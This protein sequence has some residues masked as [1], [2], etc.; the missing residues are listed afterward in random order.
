[1]SWRDEITAEFTPEQASVTRLTV[2]S[3]P[4]ELLLEQ[5][6]LAKLRSAGFELVPFDDHVA[7][8][9]LY[10]RRFRQ[11]WDRGETTNLVVVLRTPQASVDALP[12]DLLQ[13][14][15]RTQRVL[16]FG[17]ARV[18][19]ELVP[20]VVR[21]LDPRWF[22]VLWNA[23]RAT[24]QGQLN[25]SQTRAFILRVVFKIV[26]EHIETPPQMLRLLLKRHYAGIAFPPVID[27]YLI[28]RLMCSEQWAAWPL[29]IVVPE[30]EAF[31]AFLQERWPQFVS[32]VCSR[33]DGPE[34]VASPAGDYGFNIPGPLDLPFGHDDVKAYIDRLFTEGL[35]QRVPAPP[36]AAA[37]GWW[38]V[39]VERDSPESAHAR[40][41]RLGKLVDEEL[42]SGDAPADSWLCYAPR[43][44]EWLAS[45]WEVDTRLGVDERGRAEQ[46]HD[47][48]E[49]RFY[50][51]LEQ[52]Y[53][54]LPYLPYLPAPR[55][56]H[57]VP[58]WA[59]HGFG[60]TQKLALVV[61]DGLAWDQ[62]VLIRRHLDY[63]SSLQ[64]YMEES[65]V[66]AWLPTL[67][68][69]SRQ[70]I[71]AGKSPLY[72]ESSIG[73]LRREPDHW[74]TLWAERGLLGPAV[75]FISQGERSWDDFMEAVTSQAE[76]PHCRALGIVVYKLDKTLHDLGF[77]HGSAGMHAMVRHWAEQGELRRL[78]DLLMEQGFD[79]VLTADH[80]N[81][82][83][84]GI[85]KP[86]VGQAAESRGQRVHIFADDLLRR[87]L[88]AKVPGSRLWPGPGV[89]DSI[90]AVFPPGR[91]GFV[92]KGPSILAHGGPSLEEVI[93]PLVRIG[94]R[95]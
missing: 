93:V 61:V 39:G 56:V 7:F 4:D 89:P 5:G 74:K 2:V 3:D 53:A 77:D 58:L 18:F 76:H 84:H 19:P 85:G 25:D 90:K 36:E 29:D 82:E 71:F 14:A 27:E 16:H 65:A 92:K 38:T 80:G 30:R 51:W 49:D 20:S 21:Q 86:N 83:A 59:R 60:P 47:M 63:R 46:L 22:D 9:F 33:G 17:I 69:I 78:L 68:S 23:L 73:H 88:H 75:G 40:F 31:F 1:L 48:V 57:H 87:D 43:F 81:I 34:T 94:R 8:R 45:R 50:G 15:R 32:R 72:F 37:A 35:L 91:A 79:V 54:G 13:E 95:G 52:H 24:P 26:P 6:V 62:W 67:T 44:A 12:Y 66:F 10:E 42:P 11:H 55:M 70:S 28:E 64:H 41:S